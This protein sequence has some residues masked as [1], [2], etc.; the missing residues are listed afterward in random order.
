MVSGHA[1]VPAGV[2][3]GDVGDTQSPVVHDG[4]SEET[5]IKDILNTDLKHFL[6]LNTSNVDL[7]VL[8]S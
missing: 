2:G 4:L 3:L 8:F 7:N 5:R 6:S 1:G